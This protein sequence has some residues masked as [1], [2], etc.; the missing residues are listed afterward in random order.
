MK[1][2]GQ[3]AGTSA[4]RAQASSRSEPLIAV[5]VPTTAIRTAS[6]GASDGGQA[7]QVGQ[8]FRMRPKEDAQLGE[9]AIDSIANVGARNDHSPRTAEAIRAMPGASP[10]SIS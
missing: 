9:I 8:C 2:E 3:P 1:F 10:R 5:I 6:P 7:F 4:S